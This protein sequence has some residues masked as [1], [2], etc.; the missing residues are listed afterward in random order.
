M[1]DWDA[2]FDRRLMEYRSFNEAEKQARKVGV[3]NK[4]LEQVRRKSLTREQ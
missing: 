4:S 2:E 1:I 3:K